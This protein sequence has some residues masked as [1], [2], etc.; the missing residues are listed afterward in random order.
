MKLKRIAALLLCA[1]LLFSFGGCKKE[2]PKYSAAELCNMISRDLFTTQSIT[3]IED[4]QLTSY[5][6]FSAELLKEWRVAV[7]DE[8][9]KY[10]VAAVFVPKDND[11]EK[12]ILDSVN[13]FISQTAA[14]LKN[15]SDAEYNKISSRL[16]YKL[17]NAVILVVTDD[18]PTAKKYLDDLG[19][20]EYK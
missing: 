5:F 8:N 11:S 3:V 9:E 10:F 17:D 13:K 12:I 15:L 1:V 16:V 4:R 18:Y 20:K 2:Q 7:S 14:R 19:A 6:P